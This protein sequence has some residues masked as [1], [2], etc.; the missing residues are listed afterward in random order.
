MT[1]LEHHSVDELKDEEDFHVTAYGQDLTQLALEDEH[2]SQMEEEC[3]EGKA[4]D[5][6]DN[7]TLMLA[8]LVNADS[9]GPDESWI[10]RHNARSSHH[11]IMS[12]SRGKRGRKTKQ[13]YLE[14]SGF[15]PSGNSAATQLGITEEQ[16]LASYEIKRRL[17]SEVKAVYNE[18]DASANPGDPSHQVTDPLGPT[19][20]TAAGHQPPYGHLYCPELP[21]QSVLGPVEGSTGLLHPFQLGL[22]ASTSTQA[23]YSNLP[24][25]LDYAPATLASRHARPAPTT[26]TAPYNLQSRHPERPLRPG[27]ATS[28]EM[29]IIPWQP[30]IRQVG[31]TSRSVARDTANVR[32]PPARSMLGTSVLST[33]TMNEISA[34]VCSNLNFLQRLNMPSEI[35]KLKDITV[36]V[37]N[38][39]RTVACILALPLYHLL[40]PIHARG[41][42]ALLR[43]QKILALLLDFMW[44]D[45]IVM[46]ED[47]NTAHMPF[48]HPALVQLVL[49]VLWGE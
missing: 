25:A 31:Q 23:L 16:P 37:R 36:N 11:T 49:S 9:I 34:D 48:G 46:Y 18:S 19:L 40:S 43:Q 27:E 26:H 2:L 22:A 12:S 28:N 6:W 3:S 15:N 24:P 17:L 32:L 21:M 45:E 5:A 29:F 44:I 30:V 33:D 41:Q 47:G 7:L 13:K 4:G 8:T 39:F 42:E 10:S 1:I 38:D 20:L 35:K 14:S